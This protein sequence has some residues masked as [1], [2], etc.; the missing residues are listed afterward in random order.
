MAKRFIDIFDEAEYVVS[1]SGSCTTMAKV[2]YGELQDL[3]EV[4][5]RKADALRPKLF[6]FT[7]FLVDVLKITDTRA[8]YPAKV[9][10]HDSCHALRELHIKRQPREL[11][12]NVSGLEFVE[13]E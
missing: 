8:H 9:T 4:Y 11:L 6:E 13:M 10:L 1:P 7:E 5:R 2:F 12:K 3:P